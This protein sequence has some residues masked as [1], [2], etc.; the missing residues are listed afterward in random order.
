MGGSVPKG[1]RSREVHKKMMMEGPLDA[2]L[3]LKVPNAPNE[4]VEY[5]AFVGDQR[6]GPFVNN[7]SVQCLA[8]HTGLGIDWLQ[9]R[10]SDGSLVICVEMLAP[11]ACEI[12]DL[13]E[14]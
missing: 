4:S 13:C 14:D 6:K 2:R 8:T 9:E 7:F 5:Y 10:G 3:M 12:V 1:K 11:E